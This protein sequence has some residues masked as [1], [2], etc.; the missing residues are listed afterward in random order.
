MSFFDIVSFVLIIIAVIFEYYYIYTLIKSKMGK[1]PPFIPTKKAMLQEI[2][3]AASSVLSAPD[4]K[5]VVEPGCGDARILKTLAMAYPQHSFVGYEWDYV[6]YF[7]AKLKTRK[8]K[9]I[10]IKRQNFMT[11]DYTSTHLVVLFT[12]NEI[13]QELSAK[14]RQDLPKGAIVISESFEL[15]NFT[16]L[17]MQETGKKN[18]FFLDQ[19]LYIY[20]A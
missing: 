3:E 5:N 13:A 9:N 19:K 16:C 2:T 8:F 18:H 4:F 15:P 6:P 20:Q 1:Y 7:L 14:L 17:K 10:K 11:A 12:G